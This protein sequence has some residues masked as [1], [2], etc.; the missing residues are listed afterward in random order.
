[1]CPWGAPILFVK[2]KDGAMRICI[3]YHQLYKLTIKNKYSLSWIDDLFDQIQGAFAF[4]KIDF[5]SS[6]LQ[7][8]VKETDVFKAFMNRLGHYEFLFIPF[9][10]MNSPT[11]FMI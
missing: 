3:D 2:K 6:Y 1:M 11:E 8:K 5:R 9:G 10:L 7:L 4:S